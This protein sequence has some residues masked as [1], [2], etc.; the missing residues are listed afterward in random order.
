MP[1]DFSSRRHRRRQAYSAPGLLLTAAPRLLPAAQAQAER[2]HSSC[3]CEWLWPR[4]TSMRERVAGAASRWEDHVP[5]YW[6]FVVDALALPRWPHGQVSVE[7]FSLEV[8]LQNRDWRALYFVGHAFPWHP[9]ANKSPDWARPTSLR[10]SCHRTFGPIARL[11]LADRSTVA[12]V[13]PRQGSSTLRADSAPR[14][15]A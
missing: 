10:P 8:P 6:R 2:H 13:S 3:A 5:V 9:S 7:P 12:K 14:S 4:M 11:R 1:A 15:P